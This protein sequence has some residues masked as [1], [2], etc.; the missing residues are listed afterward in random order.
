MIQVRCHVPCVMCHVI[1]VAIKKS[2][3]HGRATAQNFSDFALNLK[4]CMRKLKKIY[5]HKKIYF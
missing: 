1:C 5:A 4:I 2:R 3:S